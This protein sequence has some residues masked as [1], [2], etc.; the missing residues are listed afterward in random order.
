M[1]FNT[2]QFFIFFAVVLGLYYVLNLRWQNVLIVIASYVFYGWWNWKFCIL[3]FVSTIVDFICGLYIP[4]KNGRRWVWLSVVFQLSMLGFFKYYNFFVDSMAIALGKLGFHPHVATLNVVLPVGIS[5]YTFQTLSYTIDLWR[6]KIRPERDFINFAAFVSF[7]PHLVAGPILRASYM[8]PQ[9]DEP[10]RV[11]ARELSEGTY[12]ILVGLV[13]KVAVADVIATA[14][15]PA[16]ENPAQFSSWQLLL[17]IYLFSLRI[18]C[19]FCGYT[20]IARGV[21]LY[22]GFRLAENF[23][24][25]YFA[26]GIQDFWRRWHISL[27]SWLR[28]YL[29]ISLG[30]NRQGR[31]ATYRNLFITML[32][33]GLWHGAS[34][35]FV[36]WGAL[37]GAYLAVGRAMGGPVEKLGAAFS[38]SG[39]SW[40]SAAIGIVFTFH[41]VTFT[42]IF[43]V[44]P[45]FHVAALFIRRL[46][47]FTYTADPDRVRLLLY[48]TAVIL[49]IDI[50]EAVT[51]AHEYLAKRPRLIRAAAYA[52]YVILL[53]V[54]WTTN[55]EPFIYFQF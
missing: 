2:P 42:W 39:L 19:D 35:S 9:I 16:V 55:F 6:G 30:G 21:S 23:H 18:Y 50:P 48:A 22:L 31:V 25:P 10:R 7:F 43:F 36:V 54:T 49:L 17:S 52:C 32:L 37:H 13:K 46:V 40:F 20:D 3:L 34:W 51:G 28:D 5:F 44:I 24:F 14:I 12:F 8:L 29:Y 45:D 47:Q 27:S 53:M 15:R 1:V 4:G 26:R 41:L 38:R 11:G 33:G